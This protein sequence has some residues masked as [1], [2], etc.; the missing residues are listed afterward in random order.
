MAASSN[1]SPSNSITPIE[2]RRGEE[3]TFLTYPEW[4]LVHSPAEYAGYVA[5]HTPTEFP[6][7]G[8]ISQF[9]R[10]Y[11]AVTEA[12]R[13]YPLNVGYHVMICVIGDQHDGRI[14]AALRLRDRD[15]PAD[16]ARPP[17]TA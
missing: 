7:C 11:A 9:W 3:Q 17:R 1:S 15:R 10:S 16:R 12:T 2:H 8:H 5:D 6:F 14:R 4:F 13:P